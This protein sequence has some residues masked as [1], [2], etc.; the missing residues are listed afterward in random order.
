[1]F[2]DSRCVIPWTFNEEVPERDLPEKPDCV[3]MIS[4]IEH[5]PN[6]WGTIDWVGRQIKP[7]GILVCD[8]SATSSE[9]EPQHLLRYDPATF[10][11]DMVARGW[12][13]SIEAPWLF[14][15]E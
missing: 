9:N 10:E 13:V 14:T 15:K 12:Q 7:G 11:I 1:M 2:T 4:M 5:L 6:P 3:L 8:Y